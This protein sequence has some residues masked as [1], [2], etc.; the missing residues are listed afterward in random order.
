MTPDIPWWTSPPILSTAGINPP[1]SFPAQ[2][3]MLFDRAVHIRWF[4]KAWVIS[5]KQGH[6]GVENGHLGVENFFYSCCW[7]DKN[8]GKPSSRRGKNFKVM[9]KRTC[10][11]LWN[12]CH[13]YFKVIR[14]PAVIKGREG[15][16]GN[17]YKPNLQ[18]ITVQKLKSPKSRT[19]HGSSF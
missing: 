17:V 5:V 9:Q 19:S 13:K 4:W 15:I 1:N 14:A 7:R 8:I 18:Q 10:Y 6:L 3:A 2:R 12:V 16:E 11:L